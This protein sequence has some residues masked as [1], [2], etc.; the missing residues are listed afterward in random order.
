MAYFT[1]FYVFQDILRLN[2]MFI[3]AEKNGV[4]TLKIIIQQMSLFILGEG[5]VTHTVHAGL[6]LL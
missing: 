1:A 5:D 4:V 2:M 3:K 6:L